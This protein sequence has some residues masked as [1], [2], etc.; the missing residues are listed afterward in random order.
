MIRIFKIILTAITIIIG[1]YLLSKIGVPVFDIVT[2]TNMVY[3]SLVRSPY[4]GIM[5]RRL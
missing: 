2:L 3:E 4:Q 5:P 1:Y